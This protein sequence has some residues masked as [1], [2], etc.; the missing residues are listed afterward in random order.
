MKTIR[1]DGVN[2]QIVGGAGAP[3]GLGNLII[4]YNP[5]SGSTVPRTGSHNLVLGSNNSYTGESG[6]VAGS[7]NSIAYAGKVLGG[8]SNHENTKVSRAGAH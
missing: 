3:T 8:Y 7:G 4:G 1:F 2:V 6:I 5:A